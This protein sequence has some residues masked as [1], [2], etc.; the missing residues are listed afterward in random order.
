[1]MIKTPHLPLVSVIRD[2]QIVH[3][4]TNTSLNA[5]G[6]AC[7]FD[8]LSLN[9][10]HSQL[11][12]VPWQNTTCQSRVD[13]ISKGTGGFQWTWLWFWWLYRNG[14]KGQPTCLRKLHAPKIFTIFLG[15][16]KA[17]FNLCAHWHGFSEWQW[18]YLT[19]LTRI[20]I[21]VTYKYVLRII[22]I[23]L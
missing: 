14:L 11:P 22:S 5:Q 4:H 12:K 20:F 21:L 1:M 17:N 7:I 16:N 15:C 8:F 23:I 9:D 18:H 10:S 2:G 6:V 3:A 13:L 19:N